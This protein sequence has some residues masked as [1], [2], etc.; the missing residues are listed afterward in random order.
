MPQA[1]ALRK[2]FQNQIFL[3][4]KFLSWFLPPAKVSC[5]QQKSDKFLGQ[6]KSQ[7]KS[8]IFA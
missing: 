1:L 4:F 6:P 7:L 5:S 3:A 8:D 2:I